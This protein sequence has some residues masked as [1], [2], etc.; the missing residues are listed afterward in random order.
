MAFQQLLKE[1]GFATGYMITILDCNQIKDRFKEHLDLS[2]SARS[3]QTRIEG[4]YYSNG[5]SFT[6]IWSGTTLRNVVLS[7]RKSIEKGMELEGDISSLSDD[8]FLILFFGYPPTR[9]DYLGTIY[10]WIDDAYKTG[11]VEEEYPLSALMNGL[12]FAEGYERSTGVISYPER[13]L[14]Q[15]YTPVR[16]NMSYLAEQDWKFLA[17]AHDLPKDASKE[18][19]TRMVISEQNKNAEELLIKGYFNDIRGYSTT[20]TL[21]YSTTATLIQRLPEIGQL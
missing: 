4:Y 6:N 19:I 20:S 10:R 21:G 8:E 7:E 18:T 15:E 14:T 12:F 17:Q 11:N 1:G 9:E 3:F 16:G 13:R 2:Y 5:I